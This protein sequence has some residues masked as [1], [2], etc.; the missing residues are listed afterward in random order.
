VALLPLV[1]LIMAICWQIGL[2]AMSSVWLNSAATA[3]SHSVSVGESP[4]EVRDAAKDRVPDSFRDRV[5]VT[6]YVGGDSSRVR[7]TVNVPL[8]TPAL[9][10]P[11]SI[12]VT[13]K[14]VTEE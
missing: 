1:L 5:S 10:S 6:P 11:W 12:S 2:T 7:V 9:G 8:V 4:D 3:A 13:R 14:V